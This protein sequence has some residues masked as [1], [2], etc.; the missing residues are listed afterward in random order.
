MARSNAKPNSK[1]KAPK[2]KVKK[3]TRRQETAEGSLDAE[4]QGTEL[5]INSSVA[6]TK[7]P[8]H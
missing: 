3:R 5:L 1:G 2:Q 8:A 6:D 4:S 7:S